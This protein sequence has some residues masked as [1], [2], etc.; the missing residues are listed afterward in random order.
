MTQPLN[1]GALPAF[2]FWEMFSAWPVQSQVSCIL[3]VTI[4]VGG[5]NLLSYFS[6]RRRGIPYYKSLNPF[7]GV[8]LDFNKTELLILALLAISS[9]AIGFWGMANAVAMPE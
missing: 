8:G 4:W 5:G 9:L 6:L 1:P 7:S 3:V 2:D